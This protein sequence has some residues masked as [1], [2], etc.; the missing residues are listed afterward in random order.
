VESAQHETTQGLPTSFHWL[1]ATQFLGALNDNV[2][3]L[4][5]VFFLISLKG[6]SEAG[7]IAAIAGAVLVVPF[8]LFSSFAG[9]LA[10]L[11]SKRRII[12]TVK[13]VEV[14]V[15]MLGV[16]AFLYKSEVGLYAI[17][18]LMGTHSAF[19]APSKYGIVPELV[20]ADQLSKANGLMESFT[21]LAIIFGTV[22][23]S[24][25]VEATQANYTASASCSIGIAVTGLIMGLQIK[26][27]AAA[28]PSS[29]FSLSFISSMKESLSQIRSDRE[30]LL[31]VLGT[32]YLLL[33]A[34][35][36][37]INLIPYGMQVLGLTQERSGYLF[38]VA[39]LGI[40][41]GSLLA[42][43]LS[44]RFVEF[45]VVPLG[46][47][48]LTAAAVALQAVPSLFSL[49]FFVIFILGFSAGLFIVPLQAFIQLSSPKDK[50]GEILA[51]SV[52][53]N[54]IGVLIAAIL[55]Y[56]FSAH[57]MLSASQGFMVVGILTL[58]LS[59]ITVYVL[60]DF[61]IRFLGLILTRLCYRIKIIGGQ[62]IPL[63]GPAL[64]VS[65]HVTWVDVLFIN[66]TQQ[67]RIRFIME[68]SVYDNRFLNPLFRLMKVIP[69]SSDDAPKKL[70]AFF[71]EARAALDEGYLVCIFAEGSITRTGML[72]EFRPGF[73]KFAKGSRA[74]IIPVYIGG[75]WGSIFSYAYGKLAS[76]FP[77][78]FPYPITI[79]FG[80]PLSSEID[81]FELN[82]AV[83]K[84]SCDYFESQKP[85]RVSL[86]ELF[87][88]TGRKN[89]RG[90]AISDTL[91]KRLSY[92]HTLVGAIA[93]AEKIKKS[94]LEQDTIGI[95][96]PPS[97]GGSLANLAT[98]L[99]GKTPVNLNYTASNES[100]QSSM[101]QCN[102]ETI[103]SSRVFLEK[104]N[105]QP[106]PKRT[107]FIEDLFSN[108]S[109]SAKRRAWLKARLLPVRFLTQ[110]RVADDLATIIFSSGSTGDPKGVMLTHHN[111]L[112]NI[113]ALRIVFRV[114]A[115]DNICSALPFFHSL[116]FTGTVWFPLLSGF[117]AVYHTN[118]LDGA[119]IA[120]VVRE[121]H[122]T[123]LLATP[124][125][126]LAYLRR[127]TKEDFA[128]LRLVITGAEKLSA[129][130]A[131]AFEE[132]FGIRPLEGY[133]ATELSPVI[134]LNLPDV[135]I[136]GVYQA[137]SKEGS[138]GHPI[139]G[140]AIQV[141][142]TET[143][144]PLPPGESGLIQVK[145]PN[146]MLGYLNQPKQTYTAIHDGW[147]STGDIGWMDKD[148]FLTITDRLSR[149]S[150]IGGEM[151]PHLAIEEELHKRLGLSGQM[152]AVTS[153]PD[154]KKGEK[155]VVLYI[156]GA[157]DPE[158]FSRALAESPLPNLWKPA[159]DFYFEI[160][161]LPILGTGKLDIR[162]LRRIALKA[163]EKS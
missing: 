109:P 10:D 121:N 150:K 163:V 7:V 149:F 156:K 56:L 97:V 127:A 35:F 158:K 86:G 28:R 36:T 126:L 151:V 81:P 66:A 124:T 16:A 160:E 57:Q 138:A 145:G 45:G 80:S 99:L 60:P 14:T 67:R 58:V 30:L 61:L 74:P 159:R 15:T 76:R 96:L 47:I 69:V 46:A 18:F 72:H 139:T 13:C 24:L 155:L 125:F 89:W 88:K 73:E 120:E 133:G 106:D 31:A 4:L 52:F 117:S 148:G 49:I 64:L 114:S 135:E 5:M 134:S 152:L 33:L 25:L 55:S 70:T 91:G 65:N 84:L 131:D 103:I 51:A 101:N 20:N 22:G 93:L 94:T 62:N 11:V 112:S 38:L 43:K 42:G 146:L 71:S 153:I 26:K 132:K 53:L 140:V 85:S 113:E 115:E 95:L 48:G 136:D 130:T 129:R 79:V 128:S 41:T 9:V 34:A 23:A 82:Q 19:F 68:R 161:A 119:K 32:S 87:I 37:Q 143:G 83:T 110:K 108:I 154:E 21:Y 116:G 104:I 111:I 6:P 50:R 77:I 100:F 107:I 29:R 12:V 75:G 90:D 63:S 137:G 78:K 27:T 54:W 141:I 147:Y 98:V 17:L 123:L 40:G 157:G 102:L 39:A 118:P 8:L 1:N 44:G 92:G 144:G 59:I 122:S 142:D 105:T 162:G 3:K 2:L